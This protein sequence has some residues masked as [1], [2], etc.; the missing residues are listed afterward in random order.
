MYRKSIFILLLCLCIN[1]MAQQQLPVYN[2]TTDNGQN[3]RTFST[4]KNWDYKKFPAEPEWESKRTSKY[5]RHLLFISRLH[6]LGY[7]LAL[8]LCIDHDMS[9][10]EE[11]AL[12]AKSGK[13]QSG[14][15]HWFPHLTKFIDQG[16][17]GFKLD[18]GRTLDE[19]PERQYYNGLTDDEMHNM[20]QVLVSKQMN[21]T[22]RWKLP[23]L[24][25]HPVWKW[26]GKL[27]QTGITVRENCLSTC[28]SRMY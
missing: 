28:I 6:K 3:R 19:H 26:T 22:F 8:W 18:P 9:I 2:L 13:P 24:R 4:Q 11:D 12:S 14:Q 7:K 27:L 25:N 21:L 10:V 1:T 17:D 5:E 20:N 23:V 16:V 15:E